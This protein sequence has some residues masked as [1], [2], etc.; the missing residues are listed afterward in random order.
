[1]IFKGIGPVAL[2]KFA[3]GVANLMSMAI[4]QLMGKSVANVEVIIISKL[5]VVLKVQTKEWLATSRS[6]SRRETDDHLHE[7]TV[8]AVVLNSKKIRKAKVPPRRH[9]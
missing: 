8:A 5:F 6:L 3:I 2:V 9:L 1:M 7:A 4:A